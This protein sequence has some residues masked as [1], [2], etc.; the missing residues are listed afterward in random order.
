MSKDIS[1]SKNSILQRMK[2]LTKYKDNHW[3]YIGGKR[4]GYGRMRIGGR[5]GKHIDTHRLS[6]WIF[7]DL[8]LDSTTQMALHKLTCPYKSCWNPEC[9]YVGNNS[10]NVKDAIV[11]GSNV[12]A[13]QREKTHCPQ[14]HPYDEEN[15]R[16]YNGERQCWTCLRA[17]WKRDNNRR[18]KKF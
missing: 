4:G 16:H 10:Q 15:T 1:I 18:I 17:R 3:L 2:A 7:L 12:G 6:A 5:K 13:N 9:L 11:K 8:D 14:G